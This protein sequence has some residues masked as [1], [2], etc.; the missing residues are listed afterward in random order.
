VINPRF[1]KGLSSLWK[2]IFRR[3]RANRTAAVA[4]TT[5]PKPEES[6]PRNYAVMVPLVF[7]LIA[8]LPSLVFLLIRLI[9]QEP[10]NF[11]STV[12]TSFAIFIVWAGLLGVLV[13]LMTM[14][15]FLF[16]Y[17]QEGRAKLLTQ[18]GQY[19]LT[20]W[21][22]TSRVKLQYCNQILGA[23]ELYVDK[24]MTLTLA[25]YLA[26]KVKTDARRA[27]NE[28]RHASPEKFFLDGGQ[29]VFDGDPGF[30]PGNQ[31]VSD[32]LGSGNVMYRHHAV[33]YTPRTSIRVPEDVLFGKNISTENDPKNEISFRT[34]QIFV[35]PHMVKL[36]EAFEGKDPS[37][38]QL[39]EKVS[40]EV[41]TKWSEFFFN[42]LTQGL[43]VVHE[44]EKRFFT[45]TQISDYIFEACLI[46][47]ADVDLVRD[48][49]HSRNQVWGSWYWLGVGYKILTHHFRWVSKTSDGLFQVTD[50][51]NMDYIDLKRDQ[52]VL[53]VVDGEMKNRFPITLILLLE[54][55]V[56][57]PKK[58]I[59]NVQQWLEILSRIA[60][61]MIRTMVASLTFDEINSLKTEGG[62][63]L[64]RRM[65]QLVSNPSSLGTDSVSDFGVRVLGLRLDKIITSEEYQKALIAASIAE[66]QARAIRITAQAQ[67]DARTTEYKAITAFEHGL[68]LELLRALPILAGQPGHV[69]TFLGPIA[70]YVKGLVSG[71]SAQAGVSRDSFLANLKGLAETNDIPLND[72]LQALITALKNTRKPTTEKGGNS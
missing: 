23:D 44:G 48:F 10:L 47:K 42:E 26:S 12:L 37:L 51:P 21:L 41:D 61:T 70:D 43:Y 35:D 17:V 65:L 15:N 55:V 24:G 13:Y 64:S 1:L 59:L 29:V 62:G 19:V 72:L 7:I 16:T 56:V 20:L 33:R 52:Y 3:R 71:S 2:S 34:D 69:V 14:N 66:Q 63:D 11:A 39:W 6:K 60:E 25:Q 54:C 9:N 4:T 31:K 58:A 27:M 53:L 38:A 40:D 50:V 67:A 46:E 57:E 68:T 18:M 8:V 45:S 30:T 5:K 32:T 28:Y 36:P 22:Y 49:Q